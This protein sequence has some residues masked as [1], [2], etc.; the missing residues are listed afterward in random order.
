MISFFTV[1]LSGTLL[2]LDYFCRYYSVAHGS[3]LREALPGLWVSTAP[4][5][6]DVP[7]MASRL[8]AQLTWP[9]VRPMP[10]GITPRLLPEHIAVPGYIGQTRR[11]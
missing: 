7:L 2:P 4:A 3:T 1:V 6:G 9:E 10:N 11:R 8:R 5:T